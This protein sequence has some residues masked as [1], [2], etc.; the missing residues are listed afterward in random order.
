[1]TQINRDF[2]R[3]VVANNETPATKL[4]VK[5]KEAR[6]HVEFSPESLVLAKSIARK[7]TEHGGLCLIADY[8]HEGEGTDTFRAFKEHKLHDPL[9][10]PGTA[11]LTA[12]VD[13][14]AL[15]DVM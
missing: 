12:D 14:A 8:G 2:S 13:F 10:E 4:F 6:D 9:K 11:D 5:Q 7:V 1:M 15:K 3:Y